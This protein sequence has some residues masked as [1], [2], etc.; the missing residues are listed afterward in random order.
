MEAQTD[1]RPALELRCGGMHLTVQR[2]PGWLVALATA[3][4]GAAGA[5]WTQR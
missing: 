4:G 3:F 2:I 5:W 1:H